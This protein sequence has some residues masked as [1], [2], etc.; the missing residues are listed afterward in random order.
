M[1]KWQAY[2]ADLFNQISAGMGWLPRFLFEQFPPALAA[3]SVV[4]VLIGTLQNSQQHLFIG[5]LGLIVFLVISWLWVRVNLR[6]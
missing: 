6:D 3:V 4:N 1:K 5:G 2:I